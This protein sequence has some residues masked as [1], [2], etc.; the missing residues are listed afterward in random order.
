M[1][2]KFYPKIRLL[3]IKQLDYNNSSV[4]ANVLPVPLKTKVRTLPHK[5]RSVANQPWDQKE[6][7]LIVSDYFEMLEKELRGIS[8]NKA[9]HNR[10]LR[11]KLNGR[12]KGSVEFK[13][14]NI[15]A[16]LQQL[17]KIYIIGYK[18]LRNFQH[19]LI[20]AVV[21]QLEAT[22]E[23]EKAFQ[24]FVEEKEFPV[25]SSL[26]YQGWVE[27]VPQLILN[28]PIPNT[29][30]QRISKVNWLAREQL[31]QA[32]GQAG[33]EL[34]LNYERW[35]L[36]SFGKDS[37]SQKVEWTSMHQGD[38]AGYDIRSYNTDGTDRFIEVKTTKL[39]KSTP[40]FF[41]KNELEFSRKKTH[42]Y[43]LCRVFKLTRGSKMFEAMGPLDQ[44]CKTVEAV[45]FRG[46]F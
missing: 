1:S 26:D 30:T 22:Q 35:R 37:L 8:Y 41:T 19:D 6:L 38:G 17:G 44:I 9:T 23:L 7:E 20:G 42:S 4:E 15:S 25:R 34:V 43:N 11:M 33:E 46:G 14:Q 32:I 40:I 31:N 12:S 5:C 39:D 24:L 3:T 2:R 45:N 28:E 36:S 13:H 16:V 18:P 29:Y 21:T 27:D 10:E